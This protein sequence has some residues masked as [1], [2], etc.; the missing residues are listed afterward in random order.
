MRKNICC[1]PDK[2]EFNTSTIKTTV[3]HQE[4][5]IYSFDTLFIPNFQTRSKSKDH[6]QYFT[7][8]IPIY[9]KFPISS[10]CHSMEYVHLFCHWNAIIVIYTTTKKPSIVNMTIFANKS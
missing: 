4:D 1:K 8:C 9:S 3:Q 10:I 7:F 6:N 2:A 5:C